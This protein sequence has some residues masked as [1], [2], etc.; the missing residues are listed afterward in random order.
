MPVPNATVNA[1]RALERRRPPVPLPPEGRYFI[2]NTP[3]HPVLIVPGMADAPILVLALSEHRSQMP[4]LRCQPENRPHRVMLVRP[5]TNE[6]KASWRRNPGAPNP[7]RLMTLE[8]LATAGGRGRFALDTPMQFVS[9][10][11]SI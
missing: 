1:I 3:A 5:A 8:T 2:G 11:P 4:P 9:Y 10:L 6:E 7:D